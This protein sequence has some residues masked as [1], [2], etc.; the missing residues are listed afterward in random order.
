MYEEG[1]IC[2]EKIVLTLSKLKILDITQAHP[3]ISIPILCNISEMKCLT[4]LKFDIEHYIADS[5]PEMI[6]SLSEL[7]NLTTV[8]ID[9]AYHLFGD[10]EM[11]MLAESKNLT[12]INV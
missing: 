11:K 12:D 3:I 1:I 8:A 9:Y 7:P 2:N 4:T 6:L 5:I 10:E